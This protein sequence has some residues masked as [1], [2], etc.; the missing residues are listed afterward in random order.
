MIVQT[1]IA[2]CGGIRHP[3]PGRGPPGYPQSA[4]SLKALCCL[5][6]SVGAG[7]LRPGMPYPT[8]HRYS[9]LKIE[10]CFECL[11]FFSIKIKKHNI[12]S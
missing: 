10:L 7:L 6:T 2:V 5:K 11:G 1:G 4:L 3:G 9:C 8:T 12:N